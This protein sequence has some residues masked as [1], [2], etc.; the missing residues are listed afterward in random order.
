MPL[1]GRAR[2]PWI[3][4]ENPEVDPDTRAHADTPPGRLVLSVGVG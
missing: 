2:S 1:R 4:T 3:G